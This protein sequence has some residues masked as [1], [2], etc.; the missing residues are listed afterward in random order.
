MQGVGSIPDRGTKFPT[1]HAAW[2]K[3]K[4]KKEKSQI[5]FCDFRK[6]LSA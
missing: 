5:D 3:K 6:S 2:Q 4:K 1:C